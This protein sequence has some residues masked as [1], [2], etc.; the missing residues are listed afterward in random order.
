MTDIEFLQ[1]VQIHKLQTAARMAGLRWKNGDPAYNKEGVIRELQFRPSVMRATIA[2]IKAME[3]GIQT[4]GARV[5]SSGLLDDIAAES[6]APAPSMP[7]AAPIPAPGPVP[8]SVDLSAYVTR[9]A[10]QDGRTTD[11][12]QHRAIVENLKNETARGF[13][14]RDSAIEALKAKLIELEKRAPVQYVIEGKIL[15]VSSGR[16]QT[17]NRMTFWAT[18]KNN[19]LLVGPAS[20]GKTTAA[21]QFAQDMGLELYSQPLS[22]S[23]FD[24]LGFVGP[25]GRVDTEFSRAWINGGIFLWDELSMSAKEAIGALNAALAN[26]FCSFPGLGVIKKHDNFRMIAGDNSD[27][28]G[29]LKY[30]ARELLDGASL[31]RFVRIDWDIDPAVEDSLGASAPD[32]LACVRA[33]REFIEKRG[34]EH[35]GA[36]MRATIAGCMAMQ[37]PAFKAG[38]IPRAW[39][40]EDTCRKGALVAEWSGVLQLPAVRAFLQGV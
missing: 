40:L 3:K 14:A 4:I 36:T 6:G 24:V 27:I 21:M 7:H 39:I 29:T 32:W 11:N 15:P 8:A 20:S 13:E 37:Q 31:D 22:L 34:I 17:Y 35:V 5:D 26:G 19:I 23:V 9:V 10:W 25:Q 2:N 30:G 12:G 16:H 18:Q 38:H 28:G 33:I 1:S